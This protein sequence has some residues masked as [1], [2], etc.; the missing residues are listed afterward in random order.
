M[1]RIA[2]VFLSLSIFV[3]CSLPA[4]AAGGAFEDVPSSSYYAAAVDWAVKNQIASGTSATTFSPNDNCTQGQIITFLY[5]A[6]GS[7]AVNESSP[8]LNKS[9]TAGSYYYLPMLWAYENQ[10]ILD[11]GLN[12][13]APCTRGDTILYLWRYCGAPDVEPASQF[14]DLPAADGAF[15]TRVTVAAAWAVKEGIAAGTSSNTFSPNDICTRAQV[16][17]FLHRALAG[18]EDHS[19]T[20]PTIPAGGE[21][22]Y[23][24][25]I[26]GETSLISWH[27][28]QDLEAVDHNIRYMLQRGE[29]SI[30]LEGTEN[31]ERNSLNRY[32][33]SYLSAIKHYEEFGYNRASVALSALHSSGGAVK[34]TITIT[35]SNSFFRDDELARYQADALSSAIAVRNQLWSSGALTSAMS[36]KEKARVYFDWIVTHCDY[37]WDFGSTSFIPYGVFSKEKAVC[38]GYT[39]AYNL[40]LKLEGIDCSTEK[41]SD[42]IWTTATLDGTLYHIDATWGDQNDVPAEEYFAMTPEFSR[43]RF[44]EK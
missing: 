28:P 39:G 26:K 10:I 23:E 35:F 32:S 4:M 24:S 1:K 6:V 38:E 17:T 7:P 43:S 34:T 8:P 5:R 40:L 3:S 15:H 16:I 9:I 42:H 19:T 36:Q 29:T 12:P 22:T 2:A 30:K 13:D 33:S 14:Q 31:V 25:L 44:A 11:T 37:D 20:S 18:R 27:D 41:T 21:A